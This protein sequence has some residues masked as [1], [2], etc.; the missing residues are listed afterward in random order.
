MLEYLY[1]WFFGHQPDDHPMNVELEG[2]EEFEI[3][4]C[5]RCKSIITFKPGR[6]WVKW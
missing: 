4:G 2:L 1:C 5:S 6:G 3:C